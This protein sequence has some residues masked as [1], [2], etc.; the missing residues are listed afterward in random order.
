MALPRS[1]LSLLLVIV[2]TFLV[3]C[4]G[5][6]VATP[7]PTYTQ[8]QLERIQQYLTQITPVRDRSAELESLI[9]EKD[10]IKVSNFIHG[11]MGEARLAMTYITPNLL[12]KDQKAARSTTRELFDHL[13]KVYQAAAEGNSQKAFSNY[14][15]AYA[16]LDAF[17]QL[18]PK[19][20]PESEA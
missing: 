15:A 5:P 13:V 8:A 10:W 11:P 9:Q 7:P 19:P 14:K 3:S 12:P 4:G 17:L 16:D 1:I 6:T 18:M 2:T 20:S